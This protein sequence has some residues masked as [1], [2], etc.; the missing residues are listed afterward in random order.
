M[1]RRS[2]VPLLVACV[3]LAVGCTRLENSVRGARNSWTIP[4]TLR[5]AQRQDPDNLNPMLGTET[6]DI[7]LAMFWGAYLFRVNDRNELVPELATVV[8]TQ[9]NGGISR[10]GRTITYHLRRGV[11]WH[12]GAPFTAQDV[13]FSWRAV[14][15]PRNFALTHF[16]Y[17]VISDIT[18]V[19]ANTL[20][21][22]LK[23]PFAPF[24]TA[25]FA[26]GAGQ[27]MCILPA[28][29]LKK[30]RDINRVAYN[31]RPI[32][33]GPFIV[34]SYEPGSRVLLVA[35]DRYWRG[36]PRLKR[37]EFRIVGNDNTMAALMQS[38][39]LD[40]F[41]RAPEAMAAILRN[42]P[43]TRVVQTTLTRFYDIGFNALKPELHDI[44]VRQAL[45]YAT[46]RKALIEKIAHGIAL[47]AHTLEPQLSWAFDSNAKQYDYDPKRAQ[48][49]LDEAGW[50][51]A[52][53]GTRIKNGLPLGFELVS[54]TG[55]ATVNAIEEL[56]QAQWRQIGADVSIKNYPSGQLYATLGAGGIEQS[57]KF[58]A[59]IEN[60]TDAVDPDDSILFACGMAPPAGWNVYHYCNPR[61]DALERIALR[62]YDRAVRRKAYVSIQEA[63]N[64]E[65]PFYVL[66]YQEQFDVVNSDLMNYRP[67]HAV[68]PFWN[69][70]E[71]SI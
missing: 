38:H 42:I 5:I 19:N 11:R 12:D 43:G 8:P 3:V 52:A 29:A 18:Q 14:L 46:D 22:H 15:N 53:N 50:K 2:V 44:R 33:T 30:F 49:L 61:V 56:L 45:A 47:P 62:N 69:T 37:I 16:G 63:L 32:G 17:D 23:R 28:H 6:V 34:A 27:A 55:S 20:I 36:P 57:G 25:F 58:D 39:Q 67:A 60:W 54:F 71:W 40:F 64:R 48:T 70:W 24:V 13:V 26:Q 4:G 7:D 1:T 65:L 10:D 41:Y 68:T 21:V 51:V 31:A 66:W 9:A 59:I 35:N